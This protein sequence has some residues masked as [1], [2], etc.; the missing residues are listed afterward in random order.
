MRLH[1]IELYALF[2]LCTLCS[3]RWFECDVCVPFVFR[4]WMCAC[5]VWYPL[6]CYVLLPFLSVRYVCAELLF[7]SIRIRTSCS[8]DVFECCGLF[9]ARF[10]SVHYI[11][12]S[13]NLFFYLFPYFR[14]DSHIYMSGSLSV[15]LQNN[16]HT[17]SHAQKSD[18]LIIRYFVYSVF[19]C[20]SNV[21][22]ISSRFNRKTSLKTVFGFVAC[23]NVLVKTK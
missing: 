5:L 17:Y 7:F 10:Q 19:T 9:R 23:A 12:C 15:L 1:L 6:F 4:V 16:A 22:E 14:L 20:S 13:T 11:C 8:F 21:C 3:V 2:W 18:C